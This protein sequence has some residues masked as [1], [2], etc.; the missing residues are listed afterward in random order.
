MPRPMAD[1]EPD[2]PSAQGPLAGFRV[3]EFEALG[4]APFCGMLLADMGADVTLLERPGES[5]A[6]I[7]IGEG[8]QRVVHRGK[9][10]LGIDLKRA[11]ASDLALR[12][13]ERADV[14][15]EGFRPGVM[16]RLGLGPGPC[17]ERNPRLVYAR[18]TGWGQEG[19]LAQTPGHDLNFAAVSGVLGASRRHGAAPWAPPTFV[20]DMAGGGALLG[21]GVACALLEAR[22]SGRG[23][24]IDA[25][26][27]EG[28]ALLGQGLFN[29]DGLKATNP[30]GGRLVDSSAP[31]YDVYRCR[32]GRWISVAAMEPPFY[33]A[34]LRV[35]GL[36]D[37]PDFSAQHD[38]SR[39]PRMRRRLKSIFSSEDRQHWETIFQGSEACVAPVLSLDE[40]HRHPQAKAR[41]A[42]LELSGI[43]QP[44]PAPRLSATPAGVRSCPPQRGEHTIDLLAE[45]GMTPVG[46]S[47]RWCK[48]AQSGAGA[49]CASRKPRWRNWGRWPRKPGAIRRRANSPAP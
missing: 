24:V 48:P 9:R 25:A 19:P 35:L 22:R 12:L 28:A 4:P 11:G 7:Y 46:R 33:A 29:L 44:A 39:W 1:K 41:A 15:I 8:C 36:A 47:S 49:P 40:A 27:V 38:P 13:V 34:F 32:D 3:L 23:Q 6:S 14:L 20:A 42:F 31:F 43:T 2:H 16:E 17:L 26:M 45:A 10:S 21:F 18:M 5:P 30:L 37:D